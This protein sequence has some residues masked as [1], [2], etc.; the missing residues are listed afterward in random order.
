LVKQNANLG[1]L[2]YLPYA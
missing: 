1:H 2:V